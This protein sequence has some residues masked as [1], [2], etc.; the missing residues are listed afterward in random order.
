MTIL[1]ADL[2]PAAEP[3]VVD[4]VDG[5]KLTGYVPYYFIAKTRQGGL[6]PIKNVKQITIKL[7][8]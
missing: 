5:E 3:M 7:V 4:T 6:T 1:S 2:D 8:L